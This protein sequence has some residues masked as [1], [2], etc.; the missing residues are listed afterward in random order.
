MENEVTCNLTE[1]RISTDA[2]LKVLTIVDRDSESTALFLEFLE[3]MVLL[4]T[5]HEKRAV[6]V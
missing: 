6:E 1:V 3:G 2:E 5:V 4:W